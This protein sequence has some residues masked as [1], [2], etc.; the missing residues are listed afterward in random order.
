MNERG[1]TLIEL[2]VSLMILSGI[3]FSTLTMYQQ[4]NIQ[5][6]QVLEDRKAF[7]RVKSVVRQWQQNDMG[8]LEEGEFFKI[9]WSEKYISTT[10]MEGEFRIRWNSRTMSKERVLYAYKRVEPSRSY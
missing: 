2:A 7:W 8:A 10:M 3:L 5:S 9:E 6:G 1:F 4:L